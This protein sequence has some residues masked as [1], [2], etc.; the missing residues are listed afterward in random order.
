MYFD[1]VRR[2]FFTVFMGGTSVKA[3]NKREDNIKMDCRVSGSVIVA[4][5]RC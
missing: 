4:W 2:H 1:R 3:V 5:T